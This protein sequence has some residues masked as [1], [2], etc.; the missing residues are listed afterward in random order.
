MTTNKRFDLRSFQLPAVSD[1]VAPA[2]SCAR[3]PLWWRLPADCW[4]WRGAAAVGSQLHD[5]HEAFFTP[6]AQVAELIRRFL[7]DRDRRGDRPARPGRRGRRTRG[8]GRPGH[9]FMTSRRALIAGGAALLAAHLAGCT[10]SAAK[11]GGASI[12]TASASPSS[13]SAGSGATTSASEPLRFVVG[14]DGHF[15]EAKA[16]GNVYPKFVEAVNRLHEADPLDFVVVNGDIAQGGIEPHTQYA[17]PRRAG[18]AVLRR[19]RQ[20]RRAQ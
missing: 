14:S 2:A 1:R 9:P 20:P 6:A 7:E 5:H 11:P 17:D 10:E 16:P 4:W 13:A 8:L 3:Q 12:D 18:G 19:A 15:G